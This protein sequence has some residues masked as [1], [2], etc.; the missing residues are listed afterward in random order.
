MG[1]SSSSGDSTKETRYAPYIEEKHIS[2]LDTVVANRNTMIPGNPFL[3]YANI[4]AGSAFFGVGVSLSTLP[5][6]YDVFSAAVLNLDIDR[7]WDSIFERMMGRDE[8]NESVNDAIKTID[9]NI[10]K[11]VIPDFMVGM[12]NINAVCSSTFVIGKSVIEDSRVKQTMGVR[13][14]AKEGIISNIPGCFNGELNSRSDKVKRYASIIKEY[15]LWKTD[16]DDANYT[17]AV[18]KALWPFT[19]LSF[20]GAAIG[21]MQGTKAWQKSMAARERS[22]VSKTLSVAAYAATG[23]YI[24]TNFGPYGSAIGL[25]VGFVVGIAIMLLE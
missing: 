6:I 20:E 7:I 12:R 1:G 4:D 2:F 3:G 10:D 15:F 24:G 17:M 23:A 14:S 13:L 22:T 16:I 18:R 9:E 19:V 25:V 11:K 21:T 8:I 5:S